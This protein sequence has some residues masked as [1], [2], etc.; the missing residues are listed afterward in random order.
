MFRLMP[1]NI[2]NYD[3]MYRWVKS[4]NISTLLQEYEEIYRERQGLEKIIKELHTSKHIIE[5][6]I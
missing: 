4:Q 1:N 2:S 5:S 3:G 6:I